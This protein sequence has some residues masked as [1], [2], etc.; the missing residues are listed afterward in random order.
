MKTTFW[1]PSFV[2]MAAVTLGA[3]A[4]QPVRP[5]PPMRPR[6]EFRATTLPN[7]PAEAKVLEV[8][9]DVFRNQRRG[10]M[11]VPPDDGRILRLLTEAI[12]AKHV[13]EIGTSV[14]YSGLWIALG[15]QSTGGRLTT[16]E[17]DAGRAARARENFARAGV[18]NIVTLIEGDA[19]ETVKRLRDPIDLLFLDADKEGY[20]DYLE[21]LLPLVR[22][23]GLIVAHNMDERMAHPPYVQ[24]ITTNPAL[25][26]V[27]INL[28][29]SGIGITMKKR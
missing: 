29:T 17:I 20:I 4:Q 26:T 5:P 9:E 25:E 7:S 11:S 1:F 14:G 16:F 18:S 6:V 15:L 27:F 23:G 2:T 10:S 12:G 28:T 8:L 19:H 3:G 21:K 24:A 13:V 22:P